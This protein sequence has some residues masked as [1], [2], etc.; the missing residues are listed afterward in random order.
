ML[1]LSASFFGAPALENANQP[2]PN[3]EALAWVPVRNNEPP[4]GVFLTIR[5]RDA[6][7]ERLLGYKM[8]EELTIGELYSNETIFTALKVG[9]AGGI[10]LSLLEKSVSR[11][12]IMASVQDARITSENPYHDRLEN[13]ILTYTAAGK[14]GE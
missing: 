5:A 3:E 7:I 8:I 12:A 1:A 10:R 2:K 4:N 14:T 13:G 11:V 9:N 6:Q